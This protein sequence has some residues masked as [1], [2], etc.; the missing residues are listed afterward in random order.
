MLVIYSISEYLSANFMTSVLSNELLP[1]A[2]KDSNL[3]SKGQKEIVLL[4][5]QFEEGITMNDLM[6]L[7]SQSKQTLFLKVKKLLD[8]GFVTREKDMVYL[9][10]LHKGKMTSILEN[11]LLMQDKKKDK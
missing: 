2:I 9:Y 1:F 8:R 3:L 4:L 7:M 5:L 10:K 11:H 6:K